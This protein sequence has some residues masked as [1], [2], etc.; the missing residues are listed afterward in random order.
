VAVL[1]EHGGLGGHVAA[2]TATRIIQG[3]FNQIAPEQRPRPLLADQPSSL[4][5]TLPTAGGA[6]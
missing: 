2:P 6:R 5:T 3:Y 1:V 4:H